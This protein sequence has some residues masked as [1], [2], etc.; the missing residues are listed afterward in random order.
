[1][2]Q[3][4]LQRYKQAVDE[5]LK[6]H[7]ACLESV[8]ETRDLLTGRLNKSY[9]HPYEVV[10]SFPVSMGERGNNIS[11]YYDDIPEVDE[12]LKDWR[13]ELKRFLETLGNGAYEEQMLKIGRK[14]LRKNNKKVCNNLI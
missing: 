6:N 4:E 13:N 3:G 11:M 8:F 9:S 1:M 14:V 12:L 7:D 2:N 5:K 10:I